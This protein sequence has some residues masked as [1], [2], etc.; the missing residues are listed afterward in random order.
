[1]A[2]G[3]RDYDP[4]QDERQDA[5]LQHTPTPPLIHHE[6]AYETAERCRGGVHTRCENKRNVC[7]AETFGTG[8]IGDVWDAVGGG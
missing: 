5:E 1:M 3:Q 8:S 2:L 7:G 6:A 4:P